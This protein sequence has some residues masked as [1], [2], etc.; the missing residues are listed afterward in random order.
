MNPSGVAVANKMVMP[1]VEIMRVK[2]TRK[3]QF[4]NKLARIDVLE[5]TRGLNIRGYGNF[6]QFRIEC[7]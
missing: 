7:H 2:L 4:S 1:M 3:Y 5:S 6:K